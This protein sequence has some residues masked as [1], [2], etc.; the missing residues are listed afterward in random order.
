M[1][2]IITTISIGAV[3]IGVT[4]ILPQLATMFRTHSASGQSKLGW[5]LGFTANLA[6][7]FVNG[8]GN[9]AAVL[10]AGNLLSLCGCLIAACLVHRYRDVDVDVAA[11]V[12]A[13]PD[14]PVTGSVT[15]MRT[16]EF[17]ALREAVIAED[18]RRGGQP[19]PAAA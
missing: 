18:H 2:L 13:A 8:F 4:G 6:L 12:A 9:H 3:A 19:V 7:A 17:V 14:T 1:N 5:G 15:D 11:D 16:Q 10:A